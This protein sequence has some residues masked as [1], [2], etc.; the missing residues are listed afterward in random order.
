MITVAAR[1]IACLFTTEV[2]VVR[3]FSQE[4]SG[5]VQSARWNYGL[6]T[7]FGQSTFHWTKSTIYMISILASA[8]YTGGRWET[9]KWVLQGVAASTALGRG[10]VS[11]N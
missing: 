8:L 4:T 10:G 1:E 11:G 3:H 9:R 6:H 2:K 5:L 7:A